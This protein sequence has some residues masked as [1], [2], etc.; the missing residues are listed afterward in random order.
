MAKENKDYS[1]MRYNPTVRGGKL[2]EHYPELKYYKEFESNSD[3]EEKLV[4]FSFM[5]SDDK[6][7][8]YKISD[9]E[10]KIKEACNIL[11]IKEETVIQEL[12]LSKNDFARKAITR[13]FIINNNYNYELWSS[14]RT[15]FNELNYMLRM[16]ALAAKDPLKAAELKLK[17][18]ML[19]DE[20]LKQILRIER[21]LFADSNMKDIIIESSSDRMIHYA[22]QFADIPETII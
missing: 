14:L 8:I 17:I 12:I 19:M 11:G 22:E 2:T 4:R 5:I 15:A 18:G 10:T 7:P 9:Y 21:K 3:I 13:C 1:G 6:C 20:Y 16:P